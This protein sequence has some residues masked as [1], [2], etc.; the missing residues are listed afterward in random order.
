MRLLLALLFVPSVAFAAKIPVDIFDQS[1]L[2]N[3]LRNIPSSLS[4]TEV[5][6]GFVRQHHEFPKNKKADFR[7]KCYADYFG[8]A[9]IPSFETC[10][11]DLSGNT[12]SGDESVLTI[13]DSGVV[14]SLREAMSYGDEVKK[15]YSTERVYGQASDG[16]LRDLFRYAFICKRDACEV[17]VTSK[18]AKP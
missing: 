1:K 15:F 16:A 17:T 7:I 9:K 4:R 18:P 8:Q 12:L 11:F 2:E 10:E 3:L 13:T 6:E 5:H 14:K